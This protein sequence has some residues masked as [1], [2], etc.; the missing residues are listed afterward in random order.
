MSTNTNANAPGAAPLNILFC[1]DDY[2][3]DG[4]LTAT[5]KRSRI[6][7]PIKGSQSAI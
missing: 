5:P 4:V 6:T 2:I 7:S 3:R 1:G